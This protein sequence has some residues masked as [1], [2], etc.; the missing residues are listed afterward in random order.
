MGM[1]KTRVGRDVAE[2]GTHSG[3]WS[4]GTGLSFIPK[5]VGSHWEKCCG[6]AR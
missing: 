5:A 2:A 1:Q 4:H 6:E 3:P